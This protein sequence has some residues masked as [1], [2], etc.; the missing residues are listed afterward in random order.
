VLTIEVLSPSSMRADR[1]T[2]RRLYQDVGIPHYWIVD[3]DVHE[4]EIW[5]PEARFPEVERARV[6][7]QP[8]GARAP[9]AIELPELFRPI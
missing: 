3:A 4:V 6:T 2:K 8:D 9:L 7:W 5:T 1:F